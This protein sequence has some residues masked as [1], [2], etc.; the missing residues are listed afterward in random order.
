VQIWTLQKPHIPASFNMYL[1][2][3][4]CVTAFKVSNFTGHYLPNC[5]TINI[6]VFRFSVLF[7]I[8]NTLPK[9][10]PFLLL[11]PVYCINIYS[12]MDL[13]LATMK[14]V[15]LYCTIFQHWV[16]AESYPVAQL[17]VNTLLCASHLN[18][19]VLTH[20]QYMAP[21]CETEKQKG[22]RK[23][24]TIF[25]SFDKYQLIHEVWFLK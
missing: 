20:C 17:C 19:S 11:Q 16:N 10:G 8:R 9:F 18:C 6:D 12:Y 1:V 15:C 23:S 24:A 13:L 7:N 3:S 5:S 2:I 14:A 25:S 4:K 21:F 22:I